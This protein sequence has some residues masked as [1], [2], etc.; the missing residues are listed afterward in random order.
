MHDTLHCIL[1]CCTA[2]HS[3]RHHVPALLPSPTAYLCFMYTIAGG[4]LCVQLR[5]DMV[6]PD[7]RTSA[8]QHFILPQSGTA[9]AVHGMAA[10][11]V[12]TSV[13]GRRQV[14]QADGLAEHTDII[15]IRYL[16]RS[17]GRFHGWCGGAQKPLSV[18][19][20]LQHRKGGRTNRRLRF[21]RTMRG[22][23]GVFVKQHTANAATAA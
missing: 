8:T 1:H 20:K 12:F 4:F 16:V 2:S 23:A 22:I 15:Y 7:R 3:P 9:T 6:V 17:G 14:V 10:S 5:A 11:P 21:R 13:S 18:D 19:T